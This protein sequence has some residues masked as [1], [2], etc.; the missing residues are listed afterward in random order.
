MASGSTGATTAPSRSRIV[1]RLTIFALAA[2]ALIAAAVLWA[3]F[4]FAVIGADTDRP[5]G[6]RPS[7]A[8]PEAAEGAKKVALFGTSLL[9]AGSWRGDI[10]T[11][12]TACRGAPVDL[13]ILA[14]PGAS[15]DWGV[16]QL[17]RLAGVDLVIVEFA[18][19]DASLWRGAPF[20]QS[21][22]NH[23]KIIQAAKEAGATVFLA[24]M[25]PAFGTKALA[26]PGLGAYYAM[27]R[28][29][30]GTEDIGLI[31]D[32]PR[33]RAMGEDWLRAAI[34]D[35]LHPTDKAMAEIAGRSFEAALAPFLCPR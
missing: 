8:A 22:A 11:R 30:A 15:S 7:P 4:A 6:D 14:K 1:R 20:S 3:L 13:Q 27:Y 31:D 21:R 25:N 29:L 10:T 24:T 34:P 5:E 33:W 2:T 9:S 12:L 23:L 18:I 26:R 19:N 28:E 16:E 17:D 32:A 35:D